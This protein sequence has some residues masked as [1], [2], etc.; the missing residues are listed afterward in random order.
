V[1]FEAGYVSNT[2]DELLLR[3]PD[4]RSKIVMALAQAIEADVAAR[5]RRS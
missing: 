4:Y 3:S 1:L 5:V 2:D